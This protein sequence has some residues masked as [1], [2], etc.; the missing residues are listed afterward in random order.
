[1]VLGLETNFAQGGPISLGLLR[2]RQQQEQEGGISKKEFQKRFE[3]EGKKYAEQI[4]KSNAELDRVRNLLKQIGEIKEKDTD[5]IL[6]KMELQNQA[7]SAFRRRMKYLEETLIIQK[8]ASRLKDLYIRR[9]EKDIEE[10]EPVLNSY[11]GKYPV[12]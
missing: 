6:N 1:M 2:Y 10:M 7:E 4:G 11:R 8:E 5:S 9:L 3:G 12:S